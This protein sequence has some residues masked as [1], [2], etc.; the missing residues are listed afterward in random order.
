M[1]IVWAYVIDAVH[2]R[3]FGVHVHIGNPFA[4]VLGATY[5]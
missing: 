4:F 5:S 3:D 1:N 2:T